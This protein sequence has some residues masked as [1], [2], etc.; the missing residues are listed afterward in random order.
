MAIVIVI[1]IVNVTAQSWPPVQAHTTNKPSLATHEQVCPFPSN[2]LPLKERQIK[3]R[4][5]PAFW[6]SHLQRN[7]PPA[8]ASLA[9]RPPPSFKRKKQSVSVTQP[10]HEQAP[11]SPSKLP[12]SPS[13]KETSAAGVPSVA[14]PAQPAASK[15]LHRPGDRVC[16][17]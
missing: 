12:V 13:N 1:V 2:G 15:Y 8:S 7:L 9:F 3:K 5:R 16:W 10:T 6:E 11:S 4:P 14:S 17:S